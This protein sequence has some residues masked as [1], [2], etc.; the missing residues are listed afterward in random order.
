MS[1][2]KDAAPNDLIEMQLET[3]GVATLPATNGR[4]FVFTT[5]V[6]EQLLTKSLSNGR[7]V[8]FVKHPVQQ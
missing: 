5:A 2:V 3:Q 1:D 7:V 4:I 8:L 6:L